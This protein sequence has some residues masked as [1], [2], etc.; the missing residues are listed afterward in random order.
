MD[1]ARFRRLA[2]P[3]VV[4]LSAL[5]ALV[6]VATPIRA[7]APVAPVGAASVAAPVGTRAPLG[8]RDE[9]ELP[10]DL[11]EVGITQKLENE[12]P[13]ELKFTDENGRSV[14]LGDYFHDG[15]P[16]LLSLVYYRCPMLCKLVLKGKVDLLRELEWLPGEE[17]EV[18]TVTIDPREKPPLA[19]QKKQNVIEALGRPAAAPGWHF[20][21]GDRES[22]E[23]L[24][25]AIGFGYRYL[26]DRGEYAHPAA[27]YVVTPEGRMSRYLM[28]VQH[29][30]RTVRLSLVEASE[31]RIGTPVDQF[32]LYCYQYDAEEGRYAPVALRLMRLGGGLV[33]VVLGAALI[34]LWRR[35]ARQRRLA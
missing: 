13:L 2:L 10:Q 28:G 32:L 34:I 27:L 9:G 12:L 33:A 21:T 26:P 18:V 1:R 29:D 15:R 6:G 35:E 16:V 4:G 14:R 8:A 17:F 19:R 30:P 24:T 5:A 31:G 22:I 23:R 20:L 7:A 3:L 25:D 11:Q